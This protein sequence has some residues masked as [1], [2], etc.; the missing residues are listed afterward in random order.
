[1]RYL[2]EFRIGTRRIAIDAPTY[3]IADIAANHD[4]DL[5]RAKDLIWQAKSAGADVAKFQHFQAKRIVSDV[6]FT[7]DTIGKASHQATWSRSVSETYDHYHTRRD[8]TEALVQT[9]AEAGIEFMTTPYDV[10]AVQI[11][12]SIVNAYKIGSGDI[13][14]ASLIEE[15]AR[16]GRPVLLATGAATMAEVE[17]AVTRCLRIN[18]ELCLMQCNTNY[19]GSRENFGSVNLRVLETFARYWPGLPL[20]FSDH[21]PGHSAVLG[22]VAIGARVIEKHFTDD[23]NRE[24]PDHAFA[25][26]P[27]TWPTMVEATRELEIALGD[28]I[29]RIETNENE[30]VVI[31]RRALRAVTSLAAGT[32]LSESHLEALRPCPGDAVTPDRLDEVLGRRI[33]VDL[34]QGKELTWRNLA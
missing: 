23:N 21:T 31:Q 9:C 19:T 30:T 34:P 6:G 14:F 11:F 7:D 4:G 27:V 16:Q 10:E 29:K 17:R 32:I 5:E 2:S 3:F 8:W 20:G 13:T 24:G 18:P 26:N 25:M 15:I 1:V 12:S 33:K 28:G 22:A